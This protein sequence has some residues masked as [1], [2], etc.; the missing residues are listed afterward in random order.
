M[1]NV[2][3]TLGMSCTIVVIAEHIRPHQVSRLLKLAAVVLVV[4]LAV[5]AVAVVMVTVADNRASSRAES[6]KRRKPI[7][8]RL[9]L[10]IY[11]LP[12]SSHG[13]L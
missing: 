3:N 8:L 6:F 1:T 7:F 5:L 10:D 9:K 2:F 4:V 12:S 13:I 11:S